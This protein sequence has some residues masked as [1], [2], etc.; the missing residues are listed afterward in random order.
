MFHQRRHTDVKYTH[1]KI[2]NFISYQVDAN[3]NHNEIF[4]VSIRMS[5]TERQTLL[6]VGKDMQQSVL[7]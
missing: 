5:N 4:Y 3:Q 6:C 2:L 1:D 7:L